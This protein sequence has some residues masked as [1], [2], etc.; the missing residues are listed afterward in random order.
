MANPS[1]PLDF[2]NIF[3]RAVSNLL[4]KTPKKKH[5][6]CVVNCMKEVLQ[7]MLKKA[8]YFTP[9]ALKVSIRRGKSFLSI[10]NMV[11]V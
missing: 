2:F 1:K 6:G 8:L 10:Q 5:Y 11:S 7:P 3:F 9:S 4:I